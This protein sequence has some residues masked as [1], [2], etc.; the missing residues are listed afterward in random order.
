VWTFIA[1]RLAPT[2]GLL[3]GMTWVFTTDEPDE[4]QAGYQAASLWLLILILI[5]PVGRPSA[6]SA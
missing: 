4:L 2:G 6:G 5:C 3:E 1:S